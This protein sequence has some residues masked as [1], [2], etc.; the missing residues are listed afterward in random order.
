[1][2]VAAYSGPVEAHL[3]RCR[4]EAE[5][6]EAFVADEHIVSLQWLYSAAVGGA[7]VQVRLRD[8]ARARTLLAA[9]APRRSR[10]ALFVTDD[11]AAPR[12]PRCGSLEIE[13][14]FARRLSFASALLLGFPLLAGRGRA[15]CRACGRRWRRTRSAR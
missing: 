12:C 3:A 15:R 13:E 10:S 7:K 11:L 9:P 2:A 14:R 5:G 4:L 1:V 6:I 8:A